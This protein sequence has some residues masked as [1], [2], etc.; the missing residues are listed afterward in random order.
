MQ[1]TIRKIL[2]AIALCL[3]LAVLFWYFPSFHIAPNDPIF[4]G[5]LYRIGLCVVVFPLFAFPA[6]PLQSKPSFYIS[7]FPPQYGRKYGQQFIFTLNLSFS[8]CPS[9]IS[10]AGSIL[11]PT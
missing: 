8:P 7:S 2:F 9:A 5:V 10:N 11:Q 3:G 1:N 4:I 6:Y